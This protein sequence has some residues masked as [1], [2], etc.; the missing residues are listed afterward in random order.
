MSVASRVF[1]AVTSG[2]VLAG[3]RKSTAVCPG[4]VTRLLAAPTPS[5]ACL[6]CSICFMVSLA[7]LCSMLSTEEVW[8]GCCGSD[9]GVICCCCCWWVIWCCCICWFRCC[10]GIVCCWS[11]WDW[12]GRF[13]LTPYKRQSSNY[14]FGFDPRSLFANYSMSLYPPMDRTTIS[15]L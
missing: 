2:T 6:W 13:T 14:P 9:R 7:L 4:E 1:L 5:T 11:S 8:S 10:C 15:A 12:W 3:D